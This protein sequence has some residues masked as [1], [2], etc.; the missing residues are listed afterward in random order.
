MRENDRRKSRNL[1]LGMIGVAIIYSIQLFWLQIIDD[2]YKISADNNALRYETRY[3]A[4]GLI[5]D[6]N[7]KILVSNKITYD[8]YVTPRE[9]S[10]FDTTAFCKILGVDKEMIVA[11]FAEFRKNRRKIGYQSVPL[12]KA[13]SG[14]NYYKFSEIS[15][16]MP[17]FN[18][19][20]RSSRQYPY[21]AC[22]NLL[23]YISEVDQKYLENH[24]EYRS[25]DYAGKTGIELIC[26][27]ELRGVK[28]Y[29]I[30]LRDVHNRIQSRFHNGEYDKA[31]VPGKNIQT[32]I[33][34][35]LQNYAE[36]LM[37]NKV[38]SLVAIEPSTGEILAL[39]SAP[40]LSVD[41]LNDIGLH[42]NEIIN[43]PLKPMYNRAIMSSYPPGSVF[44]MVNGLIGLQEGVITTNSRFGCSRGYVV[45]KFR[46]GCH[47]HKSPVDF[48]ESI[49]MS[50]N[51]YYCN[52]LTEILNNPKYKNIGES[53]DQWRE[54]VMS[55][56]FGTPLGCEL[57]GEL[58]GNV[59]KKETYDR[60]H[61]KNRWKPLTVISLSIGQGEMGCTP[62]QL[63]NLASIF[64]NRG[65]YYTP[66]ILKDSTVYEPNHTL[67]DR[68]QFDKIIQG[69]YL[70]VNGK[71]E[72]GATGWRGEVEGLDICGKT[73]TAQN[74][75]GEDNSV[76]IG[77]APKDHPRI[78]IAVYLENA[79]AGGTWATPLGS[80][81][82]EKYINDTISR[83]DL[84]KWVKDADFIKTR[85]K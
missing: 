6:R 76:F 45:G 85:R 25:G 61:G 83:P 39:V 46:L 70:A 19:I 64:A 50:C 47:N 81:V 9:V 55:F 4:R 66:H 69:M 1:I 48:T 65:E 13:V 57:P 59:P 63:A 56:G 60:I 33:D 8:I 41:K 21:N 14:E 11:K 31:A 44:K 22:G 36:G 52:V 71:R 37:E 43:D 79:G 51:A 20:A 27:E 5:L 23:G 2:K 49:M 58:G 18:A 34:A 75:H 7:E 77:F 53:F 62:L 29:S 32:T 84:E 3:P 72:R 68:Y 30:Y 80:L 42:Y 54:Y 26:E 16:D 35:V 12:L 28:G 17:G 15:Y 38:G 78:A 67:I 73:G 24:P 74:P 10:E 82:I 40:G